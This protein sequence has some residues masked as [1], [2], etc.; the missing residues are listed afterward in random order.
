[1]RKVYRKV[2]IQGIP[3]AEEDALDWDKGAPTRQDIES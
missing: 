2:K 1:M 3:N